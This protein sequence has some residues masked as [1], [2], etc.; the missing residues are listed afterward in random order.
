MRLYQGFYAPL[1]LYVIAVSIA[2]VAYLLL[3]A[4]MQNDMS[5]RLSWEFSLYNFEELFQDNYYVRQMTYTLALVSVISL[6]TISLA[7]PL[8]MMIVSLGHFWRTV[9][10]VG[11]F[12]SLALSEVLATYAWQL[13]LAQGSGIPG[14]LVSFGIIETAESWWPGFP[15]MFVVLVYFTLPVAMVILFPAISQLDPSLSETARTMGFGTATILLSITL[16]AL[17]EPLLRTGMLCF[18]LNIGSFVISQQLGR[19]SDWMYS[20]FIADFMS[21]FNVPL[22]VS[23]SLMLLVTSL[24]FLAVI[25]FTFRAPEANREDS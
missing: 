13:L 8:T 11:L 24:A 20:V 1:V 9:W 21:S 4:F 12:S 25:F 15:A 16:P 22:A 18:L 10:L 3:T 7:V 5:G 2:P 14:W 6:V 19:P 17:R 23:M